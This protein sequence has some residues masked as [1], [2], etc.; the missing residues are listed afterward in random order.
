MKERIHFYDDVLLFEDELSDNG[1][2]I[3]SVKVVSLY[4]F[5]IPN[6]LNTRKYCCNL[7][8]IQTRTP[9][10]REFHQKGANGIANNEDLDQT[11][12]LGVV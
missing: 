12:P 1:T 7:P 4:Y 2:S 9:N 5:K 3:L 10:L 8:K 6:V 11:A